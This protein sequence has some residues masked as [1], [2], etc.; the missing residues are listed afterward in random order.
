MNT[1]I[2][3]IL[4][5]IIVLLLLGGGFFYLNSSS[6]K[7]APVSQTMTP[8]SVPSTSS[9]Q[10]SIKSLLSSA[11]PKQCNFSDKTGTSTTNGTVYIAGGKASGNF[12][13]QTSGGPI[14]SHM[15]SDG[16]YVY[17][18]TDTM[19][20]GF[21]MSLD[22]ANS[23][24]TNAQNTQS[25]SIDKTFKFTCKD[26][27]ADS[28]KFI[29]PQDVTFSTVS[30]PTVSGAP[31]SGGSTPNSARCNICNRLPGEAQRQACL[32]QLHCK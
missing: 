1:K 28:S 7:Q 19:K 23:T 15:V 18:W 27:I 21:K 10:T 2:L 13:V 32:T 24:V 20:Q 26:W 29:L 8:T 30:A 14:A 6:K 4:G 3:A 12:N 25:P 31:T 11:T 5:V 17:I 9:T 22:Q 16:T